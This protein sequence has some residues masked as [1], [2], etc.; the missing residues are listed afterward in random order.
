MTTLSWLGVV[1]I[2]PV[3]H[4][5]SLNRAMF[6]WW[7]HGSLC[8]VLWRT[9]LAYIEWIDSCSW[10]LFKVKAWYSLNCC[11]SKYTQVGR[12]P[13]SSYS[14]CPDLDHLW[15]QD[16]YTSCHPWPHPSISS[17]VYLWASSLPAPS[18]YTSS[19]NHV[20]TDISGEKSS[21]AFLCTWPN[22]LNLFLLTTS[23]SLS[24]ITG[25]CSQC[26]YIYIYIYIYSIY[27]KNWF[28]FMKHLPTM[29]WLVCERNYKSTD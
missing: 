7:W 10:V 11:L 19:P 27:Y 25:A 3:L 15:W 8:D 9:C 17:S 6:K 5:W 13:P 29:T 21:S 22:H 24:Y 14:T 16:P 26:F 18:Y 28:D 23:L 1:L 20:C 4:L 2:E 12:F